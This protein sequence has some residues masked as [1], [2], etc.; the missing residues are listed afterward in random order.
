MLKLKLPAV[1]PL[2]KAIVTR[3][4]PFVTQMFGQLKSVQLCRYTCTK[5]SSGLTTYSSIEFECP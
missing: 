2:I 5:R 3:Y 1:E 4:D